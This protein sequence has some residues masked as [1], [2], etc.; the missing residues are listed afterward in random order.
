MTRALLHLLFHGASMVHARA[1]ACQSIKCCFDVA[2]T[3]GETL[4][5]H[6][7]WWRQDASF[8]PPANSVATAPERYAKVRLPDKLNGSE[9]GDFAAVWICFTAILSR[10]GSAIGAVD[11]L[12][13]LNFGHGTLHNNQSQRDRAV[14]R[15]AS[16]KPLGLPPI[17]GTEDRCATFV[18]VS[19]LRS[20]V[21]TRLG[22]PY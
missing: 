10:F 12:G 4:L 7:D 13:V 6:P 1:L 17:R 9:R 20:G 18:R 21:S 19:G 3:P 16:F 11:R 15:C 22:F 5:G 2:E 14:W 8:N